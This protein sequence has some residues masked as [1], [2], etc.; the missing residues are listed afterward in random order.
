MKQEIQH[1]KQVF[2]EKNDYSKCVINR[3]VEQVEAK[4]R[5]VTHSNGLLMHNLQQTSAINEE[6]KPF[7]ITSL[8]RTKK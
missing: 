3:V 2:Y 4:H 1:L 7:V 6:K 5:T 8:P